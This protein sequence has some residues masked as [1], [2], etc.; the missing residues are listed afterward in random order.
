MKEIEALL[1][2]NPQ[3]RLGFEATVGGGTPIIHTLQTY[4]ST[5]DI[6]ELRGI[7]NGSTNFILSK[8][9]LE[10]KDFASVYN[11][12]RSLGYLEGVFISVQSYVA[13]ASY[14]IEGLDA[15][16]KLVI[17]NRLAFGVFV[18]VKCL[19]CSQCDEEAI[20][21]EGIGAIRK[22]DV[23][24]WKE[25]GYHIKLVGVSQYDQDHG[26]L[27]SCVLPVVVSGVFYQIVRSDDKQPARL[28]ALRRQSDSTLEFGL[29]RCDDYR[30]CSDHCAV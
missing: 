8:M 15:R 21:C 7:I 2:Q 19:T 24:Y 23:G 26:V 27:Y 16:S 3:A 11:E 29:S 13:N 9:L 28:G 14:D 22:E 4:Y 10:K 30:Q 5:D 17:L 20:A 6:Y 18:L 12:A 1:E 25:K